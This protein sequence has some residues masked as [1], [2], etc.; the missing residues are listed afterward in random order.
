[1]I[2]QRIEEWHQMKPREQHV[3]ESVAPLKTRKRATETANRHITYGSL[4]L[5]G[6]QLFV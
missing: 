4:K 2:S 3:F 5:I 6:V 1:M